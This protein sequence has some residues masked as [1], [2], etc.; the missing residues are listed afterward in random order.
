MTEQHVVDD[1]P[2]ARVWIEEGCIQC[3]WCSDLVP[4]VFLVTRENRCEIRAE[5]RL[6][7]AT[8]D[9]R[10]TRAPLRVTRNGAD[11]TFME[12]VA[13]GCPAAVIKLGG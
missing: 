10:V 12:F 11:A 7:G 9:N 1:A 13:A 2:V 5:A 3:G 6:D 4:E 8:D